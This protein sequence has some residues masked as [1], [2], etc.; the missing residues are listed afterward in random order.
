MAWLYHLKS[1]H[2]NEAL[3]SAVTHAREVPNKLKA[4]TL[5]SIAKL[6]STLAVTGIVK[7]Q[8]NT[9]TLLMIEVLFNLQI[10]R[11]ELITMIYIL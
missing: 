3:V 5:L 10:N 9:K 8:K 1:A 2:Y 7:D 6:S 4:K 11:Y